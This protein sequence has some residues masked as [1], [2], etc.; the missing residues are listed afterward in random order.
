M[1]DFFVRRGYNVTTMTSIRT[2]LVKD[3]NSTAVRI[4]K[5]LL[6][7]SGLSGIVEIEASKGSVTIRETKEPRSGWAEALSIEDK[8]CVDPELADWDTLA[9]DSLDEWK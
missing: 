8:K 7:M 2:K 6:E 9:E 4:P 3:G 5:A 1:L